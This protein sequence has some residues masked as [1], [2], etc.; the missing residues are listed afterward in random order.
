[1]QESIQALAP[2][3]SLCIDET[4]DLFVTK[5]LKT[6]F[7]QICKLIDGTA[8]TIVSK[9]CQICDDYIWI[10]KKLCGLWSNGA[11]V[12]LGG[13]L[14]PLKQQTPFL[15]AN[16]C[17]AHCLALKGIDLITIRDFL[18]MSILGLHH[19]QTVQKGNTLKS[20]HQHLL[21]ARKRS[22]QSRGYHIYSC[23]REEQT[24]IKEQGKRERSSTP[25]QHSLGGRMISLSWRLVLQPPLKLVPPAN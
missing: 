17:I 2:F 8:E 3:Y 10:F 16:H 7:L 13:I 15:V 25:H 23:E 21:C 14:T 19:C 1:M 11:F 6:S 9:V 20:S 12:M 22:Q 5:Q 18:E 24:T 4:T